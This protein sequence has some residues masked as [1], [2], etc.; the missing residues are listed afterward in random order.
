[1]L[2][3]RQGQGANPDLF[4]RLATATVVHEGVLEPLQHYDEAPGLFAEH[5]A[6]TQR[7]RLADTM[8]G[9][10]AFEFES[11][12]ETNLVNRLFPDANIRK[13]TST[14]AVRRWREVKAALL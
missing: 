10:E 5:L 4:L 14:D 7:R 11:D 6:S 8:A 13:H 9:M 1:M 12:S 2:P 3:L